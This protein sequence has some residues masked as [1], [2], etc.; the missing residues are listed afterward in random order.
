MI[1]NKRN[2]V[3]WSRG[4]KIA[5]AQ[6]IKRLRLTHILGHFVFHLDYKGVIIH[7]VAMPPF[8]TS[9]DRRFQLNCP[10]TKEQSSWVILQS[11]K[12]NSLSVGGE[13]SGRSIFPKTLVKFSNL[14][15][16][17]ASSRDLRKMGQC[18]RPFLGVGSHQLLRK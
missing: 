18:G 15:R 6:K 5:R 2:K 7:V 3:A 1:I 8:P 4:Y 17:T 13:L 14:L 12:V 10:F 11:S 16:S 9:P